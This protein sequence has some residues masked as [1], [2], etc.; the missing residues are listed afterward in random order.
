[1]ENH[2]DDNEDEHVDE[3]ED[4]HAILDEDIDADEHA[5]EEHNVEEYCLAISLDKDVETPMR[6]IHKQLKHVMFV[7]NVI[8]KVNFLSIFQQTKKNISREVL[9]FFL[10]MT[11]T[12]WMRMNM[13]FQKK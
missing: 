9:I 4:E 10:K 5:D 13:T 1:M 11:M 6:A 3:D 8:L 12:I 2:W 7:R